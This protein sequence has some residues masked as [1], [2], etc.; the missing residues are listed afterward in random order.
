MPPMKTFRSGNIFL[1]GFEAAGIPMVPAPVGMNSVE[2]KGRPACLYDGW[3]HVGCPIGALANP[4]VTYLGDARKAGAEVR[5]LST[6]TRILT[7]QAGTRVTGVEYYDDKQ[8][9]QTQEASVV[10]LAAW[11]AQNPRL[12]LNSATDK[13]AKGLGNASGLVGHFMMT[14]NVASTWAM[15][16]EDV[17]NHMGTIAV[18]FMSYERYAKTSHPGAFGSS[19]VTA[20]FALKTSDLANSRGDL[21]GPE[22]A[23]YMKRA[24]RNLAGIKTFGED[25]PEMENRVELTSAKDEFGMPLAKLIHSYGQDPLAL[26]N[27]NLEEGLKIAK[28]SGAKEAW[29]ARGGAIP[30]SHLMGGTIMGA[31]AGDS[32]VDSYGQSHEIPNLWVAGPSIFPTAGASN[33]T[34]TIFALSQRGAE[35]MASQW[36]ALTN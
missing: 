34:F 25:Q 8:Q 22:L 23:D 16:D 33:P 12:L 10:L 18:Q 20:G 14:H 27:A 35:R 26:W 4:L 13:H 31:G 30:T 6:V 15:F 17:Q 2:F 32:V 5:A 9:K 11:S 28:A 29:S 3:C 19:F 24:A 1:K 21:F 7:N 36:A